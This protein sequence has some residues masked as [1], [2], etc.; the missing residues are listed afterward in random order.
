MLASPD[1]GHQAARPRLFLAPPPAIRTFRA[2]PQSLRS[3]G[4]RAAPPHVALQRRCREWQGRRWAAEQADTSRLRRRSAWDRA[5]LPAPNMQ[6]Q[7]SPAPPRNCSRSRSRSWRGDR[8]RLGA[9]A[10]GLH[11]SGL[12]V[13]DRKAAQT[14]KRRWRFVRVEPRH[15]LVRPLRSCAAGLVRR[16]DRVLRAR[17]P[18][19]GALMADV[20]LPACDSE[21][22]Y[23]DRS[24]VCST[25]NPGSLDPTVSYAFG[26]RR[27]AGK[28][29]RVS[30]RGLT[31]ERA[32][33]L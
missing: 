18:R 4:S 33:E 25:D 28:L 3:R 5:A 9:S 6:P 10:R 29:W 20:Q 27:R 22:W 16:P 7:R 24:C 26:A 1:R 2:A 13:P 30:S 11:R 15:G 32:V 17:L 23:Q 12:A 21:F 31:V 19:Q 8:I 14:G